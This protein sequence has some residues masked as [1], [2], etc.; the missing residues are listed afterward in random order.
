[1]GSPRTFFY[2]LLAAIVLLFIRLGATTVF[3]VA[4]GRNAQCAAEM[5]A[6]DGIVPKFNGQL[7]TDK[8]PVHYYLMMVAYMVA[9]KS[10]GASRFFS[11]VAGILIVLGTWWITKRNFSEKAATISAIILLAS[12]H[13]IFQFRLATPDPFLIL[14]HVFS[15]FA[16]WEGYNSKNGKWYLLMYVMMGLAFFAKGPVGLVLPAATV[17][18][19]L[20]FRK[21]FTLKILGSLRLIPGFLIF[22]LVALPWYFLVHQ[23]TD[24]S[25]TRGFFLEHNVGRFNIAVDGHKGPFI[26]P[27][28]FVI[29]GLFPFSVFMPMAVVDAWKKRSIV[30]FL[31]FMLLSAIFIIVPYSVSSTKLI[32]YTSP[33][34]PF[35]AILIGSYISTS[36]KPGAL[37]WELLVVTIIALLFP[38]GYYIWIKND[39]IP[40]LLSQIWTV[41]LISGAAITAWYLYTK[42]NSEHWWKILAGG[43][44]LFNMLFFA[45]IFPMLDDSGSVKKLGRF[46]KDAKTV[47]AY[48][49]LNDAFV[50]YHEK[51]IPILSNAAEVQEFVKTHPDVLVL[52]LGKTPDLTDSVPELRLVHD[53]KDLFSSQHSYI[54]LK[55]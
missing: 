39:K 51:P 6:G 9:G 29:A 34:Y 30:P 8:P 4:E 28:V 48:K 36:R 43:S 23:H 49:R 14:A 52:Q 15:L 46:V 54:Y 35:I 20:L 18:T 40:E 53:E 24:G 44:M 7:R 27:L 5:L 25:W 2:I 47:V 3:Q 38:A 12:L 33:C 19:F 26:L 1:M 16:F 41:F 10:E 17:F 21:D 42:R 22:C 37:K 50:F 55:K 11:A 32:N 45:I 13:F 31:F